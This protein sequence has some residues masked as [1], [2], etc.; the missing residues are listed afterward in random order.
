[1]AALKMIVNKIYKILV[2]FCH[3]ISL[4]LTTV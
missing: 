1:M 4:C 3:D 2:I